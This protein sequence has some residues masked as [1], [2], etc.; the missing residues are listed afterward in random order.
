MKKLLILA[1][2]TTAFAA[3]AYA[4]SWGFTLGNGSGF[5]YNQGRQ[6]CAPVYSVPAYVTPAPVYY[7]RPTVVYSRPQTVYMQPYQQM[8]PTYYPQTVIYRSEPVVI[9]EHNHRCRSRW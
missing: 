1:T 2:L 8:R 7:S 4:N 6:A 9:R 5:Y 3:S